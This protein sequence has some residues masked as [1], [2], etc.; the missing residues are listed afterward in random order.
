M[1]RWSIGLYGVEGGIGGGASWA[2]PEGKM[3]YEYGGEERRKGDSEGGTDRG[4]G[5]GRRMA[6]FE[7]R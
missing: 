7:G 2:V 5:Q 4:M 1:V 6:G 3:V